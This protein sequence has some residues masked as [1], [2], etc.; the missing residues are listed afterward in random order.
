MN[1]RFLQ[2]CLSYVE[3]AVLD[4]VLTFVVKVCARRL[5]LVI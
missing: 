4:S 5:S 2:V 1:L 3:L